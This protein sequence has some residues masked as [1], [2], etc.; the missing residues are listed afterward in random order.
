MASLPRPRRLTP[1]ESAPL[2]PSVSVAVIAL[3]G[4]LTPPKACGSA[5]SASATVAK[6]ERSI[7]SRLS[8]T[9]GEAP[10]PLPRIWLPVTTT[11]SRMAGP[12]AADTAATAVGRAPRLASTVPAWLS[13]ELRPSP[14]SLSTKTSGR[15][16]RT[17]MPPPASRCAKASSAVNRPCKALVR[18]PR[19]SSEG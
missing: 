14:R 7:E 10:A 13:S 5:P 8:S 19:T 15:L 11:S 1:V 3:V 6:P 18:R 4:E 2:V 12:V 9:I 17:T 16:R